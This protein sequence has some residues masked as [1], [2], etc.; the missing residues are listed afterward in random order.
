MSYRMSHQQAGYA[1][2]YDETIF[3]GYAGHLWETVERPLLETLLSQVPVREGVALDFACGTG[4][5]T[6]VVAKRFPQVIGVDVAEEMLR[7]ARTRCPTV[8]FL[9][10]DLTRELLLP[11]GSVELVTAFRF[12]QNAEPELREE[13]LSVFRRVL[14]PG[15]TVILN[16]QC[17][18]DG[19]AG[20]V[21]RF[22]RRVLGRSHLRVMTIQ[23]VRELLGR[24]G[25]R[26][27]RVEW[28]GFWPRTGR[29][30]PGLAARMQRP[31]EFVV[32][33]LRLPPRRCAQMFMVSAVL[34]AP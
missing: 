23:E 34:E 3:G 11:P 21:Q 2:F 27:E 10:G 15:G 25:F 5:I 4:R 30:L 6:A 33:L 31:M 22:R 14:R 28:Y 9:C 16:V 1:Q 26:I 29:H 32:R 13:V 19:P 8:T 24:H 7:R 17:N 18:A 12:F 20:L